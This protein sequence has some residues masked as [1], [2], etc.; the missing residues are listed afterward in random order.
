MDVELHRK[1]NQRQLIFASA[2]DPSKAAQWL[3]NINQSHLNKGQSSVQMPGA[4]LSAIQQ[5]IAI[6]I[7]SQH[8]LFC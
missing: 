7:T 2:I 5:S 1:M 4:D 6:I 8:E 3:D